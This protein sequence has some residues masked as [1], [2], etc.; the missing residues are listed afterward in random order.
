M[1]M[2]AMVPIVFI[3]SLLGGKAQFSL[4]GLETSNPLSAIG[5]FLFFLFVLK[6]FTALSLW[7]EKDWAINLA[8]ADAFIGIIV[9]CA[10]MFIVPTFMSYT[11]IKLNFRLELALLIPYLLKLQKIKK[12]W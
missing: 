2:G 5:I 1:I 11:G 6:G 8:I 10:V 3:I 7:T 4:Y 9:C 12:S